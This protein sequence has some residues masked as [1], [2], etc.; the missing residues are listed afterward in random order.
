MSKTNHRK[1]RITATAVVAGAIAMTGTLAAASAATAQAAP[2]Q[3][4]V[5]TR[6]W[7]TPMPQGTVTLGRDWF[8]TVDAT[9]SAFGL[10][11]GS[12]H[13]VELVNRAGGVVA[14]FGTLTANGVGQANATLDSWDWNT[15]GAWRVLILNGTAGGPVSSEPIART[16]GDADPF[17]TYQLVP[18]E[19][20][21]NGAN[22]GT[23]QGRASV[24]Y[25]PH[26]QTISVTVNASGL[27]PGAHAAHIHV[28]SCESQG[29]VQY[30]LMDFTADAN[31]Q[32]VDQTQTVMNV[33]TP[34]P[35]T[36]WYLNL[37]QGNSNNILANGNPTINFRPLLCGNIVTQR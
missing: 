8:G 26:S 2:L 31:G 4:K 14:S 9:V 24:T 16:Q 15:P 21:A 36:G 6:V 34:L 12:S 37:H 22:Y 11:P 5:T 1:T 35:A 23:P 33:T 25:N 27:T 20:S 3:H 10:T 19:E 28:G 30:M 29:A 13:A 17:H 7:L 32:I 18:V